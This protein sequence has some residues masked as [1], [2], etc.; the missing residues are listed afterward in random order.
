MFHLTHYWLTLHQFPA[1]AYTKGTLFVRVNSLSLP[2]TYAKSTLDKIT[3]LFHLLQYRGTWNV[4]Q[5]RMKRE[6]W[7]YYCN[8]CNN[9]MWILQRNV[10]SFG[11]LEN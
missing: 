5:K 9:H 3:M 10:K 7:L 6:K 11:H 1:A 4:T 2:F 8:L